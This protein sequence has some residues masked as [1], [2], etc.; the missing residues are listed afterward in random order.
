MTHIPLTPEELFKEARS[1]AA[2]MRRTGRYPA[3]MIFSLLQKVY[4]A[5]RS[6][7]RGDQIKVRIID[8]KVFGNRLEELMNGQK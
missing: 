5:G 4:S 3:T 2:K 8:R 6:E 1:L 7:G